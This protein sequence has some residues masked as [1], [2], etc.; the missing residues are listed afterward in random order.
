MVVLERVSSR[1]HIHSYVHNG[2]S[3][4][5]F[6]SLVLRY[7]LREHGYHWQRHFLRLQLPAWFPPF[8]TSSHPDYFILHCSPSCRLTN[9]SICIECLVPKLMR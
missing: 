6:E 2:Y 9:T 3:T 8:F 1:V 5:C 4:V 7:E